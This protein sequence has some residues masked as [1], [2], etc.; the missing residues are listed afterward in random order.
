MSAVIVID[1]DD[2][3]SKDEVQVVSFP[4]SASEEAERA[5]R[6]K[7]ALIRDALRPLPP[8]PPSPLRTEPER[9][10]L[11]PGSWQDFDQAALDAA[12]RLL[13]RIADGERE[14]ARR[15]DVGLSARQQLIDESVNYAQHLSH[16]EFDRLSL[17]VHG[18]FL[19]DQRLPIAV[20]SDERQRLVLFVETL[21]VPEAVVGAMAARA[22]IDMDSARRYVLNYKLDSNE[23]AAIQRQIVEQRS[24]AKLSARDKRK[25]RKRNKDEQEFDEEEIEREKRRQTLSYSLRQR[26]PRKYVNEENDG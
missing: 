12:D 6:Q 16:E 23:L 22:N 8:S 7:A 5:K 18:R 26:A 3:V 1:S 15:F 2:D 21:L 20:G 9:L 17:V 11:T 14:L 25:Q 19:T 24:F 10:A 4:L 13:G